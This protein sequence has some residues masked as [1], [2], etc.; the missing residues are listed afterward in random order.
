MMSNSL[1]PIINKRR[2]HRIIVPFLSSF[3]YLSVFVYNVF[4]PSARR[5]FSEMPRKNSKLWIPESCTESQIVSL[6]HL[7]AWCGSG[8]IKGLWI[9]YHSVICCRQPWNFVCFT[10]YSYWLPYKSIKVRVSV[11]EGQ[12]PGARIQWARFLSFYPGCPSCI[13]VLLMLNRSSFFTIQLLPWLSLIIFSTW[14][15]TVVRAKFI[16]KGFRLQSRLAPEDPL[17]YPV[18]QLKLVQQFIHSLIAQLTLVSETQTTFG[19]FGLI[20]YISYLYISL[21]MYFA[22]AGCHGGSENYF[23]SL[24]LSCVP[25]DQACQL[26]SRRPL[27]WW[28]SYLW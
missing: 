16:A 2:P 7:S 8:N 1:V 3:S 20:L 25:A 17:W 4:H 14:S 5:T 13:D 22:K 12:T 23:F 21:C 18:T 11:Y 26:T 10:E 9:W 28:V 24:P 27:L 6:I 19:F 15:F